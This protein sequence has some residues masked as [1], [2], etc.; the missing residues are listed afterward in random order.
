M[1]AR[2]FVLFLICA[3]LAQVHPGH[4]QPAPCTE[5]DG[6]G[7]VAC[8]EKAYPAKLVANISL[9]DRTANATFLRDRVIETARCAGLDVG[10]NLKRGGPSISVDFLAWRNGAITEGVDIIGSWD[11]LGRPLSLSWHRYPAPDY[12]FPFY[13]AYGPVSCISDP[14]TDPTPE[15]DPALLKRIAELEAEIATLK[16]SLVA[17]RAQVRG[18]QTDIVGLQARI[19]ELQAEIATLR[20]SEAAQSRRAD[21]LENRLAN[22]TCRASIFG[23]RLPCTVVRPE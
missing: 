23:I 13:K 14:G 11:D 1:K 7:I 6:R 5:K 17:S 16:Q 20:V 9:A 3:G 10:L 15:P 12:G 8:V 2:I 4:A 18:L 19:G 21:V 22:T